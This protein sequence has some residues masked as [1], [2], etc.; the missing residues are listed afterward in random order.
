VS[1]YERYDEAAGHYDASRGPCGFEIILGCLSACGRPLAELS[2]LDAGCG[3]GN[4]TAALLPHLASIT[5]IDLSDG[6]LQIARGKAGAAAAGKVHFHKASITNIP[7]SDQSFDSVIFNQ[8]LHHLEDGGD[9]SYGGHAAALAEAYRVLRPGGTLVINACSHEQLRNGFWYYG[10]APE[11]LDGVLARC[12]PEARIREIL[13]DCGFHTRDRIVPHDAVM[14]GDAYFD[15][16]GPLQESWRKGDSFWALAS[17]GRLSAAQEKLRGLAAEGRLEA[18]LAAADESRA[19][20][21]QLSFFWAL[22]P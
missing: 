20:Y 18:Y 13:H 17:E 7:V 3:T 1:T 10:L 6:M 16:L 22:R 9:L 14:Q 15:A 2:L 12:A 11:A 8:V 21:G 19:L 4:Y 5:A